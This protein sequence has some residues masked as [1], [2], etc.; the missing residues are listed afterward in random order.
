MSEA[1]I[2]FDGGTPSARAGL[3]QMAQDIATLAARVEALER[4]SGV[5]GSP[6]VFDVAE[7]GALSSF[8]IYAQRVERLPPDA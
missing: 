7:N 4:D 8:L 5:I 2:T 1:R 3:N 6:F